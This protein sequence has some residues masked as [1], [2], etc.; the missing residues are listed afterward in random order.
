[1]KKT[2]PQ[3]LLVPYFQMFINASSNGRR[4]APSG[5]KITAGTIQNYQYAFR[6]LKEY[7]TKKEA[8][9]RIQLLHRAPMRTLQK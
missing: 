4:L 2:T 9:L 3:I 5:K 8:V 1:M 7:E 6:L